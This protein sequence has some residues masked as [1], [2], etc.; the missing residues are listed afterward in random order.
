MSQELQHLSTTVATLNGSKKI[1]LKQIEYLHQ[2]LSNV[3]Q[4][5]S[6]IRNVQSEIDTLGTRIEADE[7]NVTLKRQTIN[8][9]LHETESAQRMAE[10]RKCEDSIVELSNEMRVF[11]QNADL[12]AKLAFNRTEASANDALQKKLYNKC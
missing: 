6:R 12:R 11:N 3:E 10:L 9:N 8:N 7:A 4:R 2:T 1:T 5:L